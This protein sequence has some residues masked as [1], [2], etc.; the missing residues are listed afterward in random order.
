MDLDWPVVRPCTEKVK[1][2]KKEGKTRDDMDHG[3][4]LVKV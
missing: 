1:W 3:V 2:L 4:T